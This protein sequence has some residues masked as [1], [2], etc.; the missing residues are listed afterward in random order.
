MRCYPRRCPDPGHSR[1]RL[2]VEAAARRNGRA[3]RERS[4][5]AACPQVQYVTINGH[6]VAYIL[7]IEMAKLHGCFHR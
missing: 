3:E 1:T 4:L 7:I 2:G 6:A 5:A